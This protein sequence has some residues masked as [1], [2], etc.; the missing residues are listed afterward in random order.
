MD[1]SSIDVLERIASSRSPSCRRGRL[2]Y[3]DET[4]NMQDIVT[5]FYCIGKTFLFLQDTKPTL[6]DAWNISWIAITKVL[7][8]R[9]SSVVS[10]VARA[11]NLLSNRIRSRN[12]F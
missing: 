12:R 8:T 5:G 11:S 1:K 7:S 3:V 10:T 2:I 9:W 4:G 6:R